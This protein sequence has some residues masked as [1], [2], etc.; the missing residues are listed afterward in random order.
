MDGNGNGRGSRLWCREIAT[1][2]IV[3]GGIWIA[4]LGGLAALSGADAEGDMT[5]VGGLSSYLQPSDTWSTYQ[6]PS[7]K[8]WVVERTYRRVLVN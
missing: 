5:A 4:G 2:W 3:G 6:D 1:A 8:Y 7:G